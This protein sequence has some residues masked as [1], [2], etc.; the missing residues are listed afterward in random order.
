MQY[1]EQLAMIQEPDASAFQKK[2]TAL[3]QDRTNDFNLSLKK[4][5]GG[6][7]EKQILQ[8]ESGISKSNNIAM[9]IA[10]QVDKKLRM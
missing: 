4:K 9:N 7:T 1:Q 8:I 5:I 10:M 3:L 6:M 2:F